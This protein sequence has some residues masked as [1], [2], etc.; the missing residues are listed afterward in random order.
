MQQC[1]SSNLNKL[2][3]VGNNTNIIDTHEREMKQQAF[4]NGISPSLTENLKASLSEPNSL[5]NLE[6]L[7]RDPHSNYMLSG[8]RERSTS[9]E[10]CLPPLQ[11]FNDH[12][13]QAN[14][15]DQNLNNLLNAYKSNEKGQKMQMDPDLSAIAQVD[16]EFGPSALDY[17]AGMGIDHHDGQA[18]TTK[19]NANQ[20]VPSRHSNE[21]QLDD[22][23][24]NL[25]DD[26]EDEA[27]NQERGNSN[28]GAINE[29]DEGLRNFNDFANSLD[30][31][32]GDGK[33]TGTNNNHAKKGNLTLDVT[34]SNQ[35]SNAF[36]KNQKGFGDIF[37]KID[38]FDN[39]FGTISPTM[40]AAP[41][42]PFADTHND[43]SDL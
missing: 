41:S 9:N 2:G 26:S 1:L 42:D 30:Q 23:D 29:Y 28:F 14:Q 32:I 13:D 16:D 43:A 4:S 7:S 37:D 8:G 3:A 6:D 22:V 5:S 19:C 36:F 31:A 11:D 24:I 40:K 17:E 21:M 34:E 15:N 18:E 10:F 33:N 38:E 25:D 12:R 20:V 35:N 27:Q 39:V